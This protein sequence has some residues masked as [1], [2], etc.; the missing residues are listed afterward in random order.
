MI[1]QYQAARLISE[2]KKDSTGTQ[3]GQTT[4]AFDPH[5]RQLTVTDAR[6]GATSYGYDDADRVVSTISPV[7]AGG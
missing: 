2:T 1:A 7:P 6:N 4:N 5:G 3:L